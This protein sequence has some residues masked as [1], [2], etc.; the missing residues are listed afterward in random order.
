MVDWSR[1]EMFAGRGGG[2]GDMA[3]CGGGSGVPSGVGC[4]RYVKRCS[5]NNMIEV[6]SPPR[7]ISQN[8]V[9]I[10]GQGGAQASQFMTSQRRLQTRN[11][12]TSF[13]VIADLLVHI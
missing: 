12:R 10:G 9:G 7:S 3:P 11:V 6:Q 1:A 4:V 5:D 2:V 13:K 8:F